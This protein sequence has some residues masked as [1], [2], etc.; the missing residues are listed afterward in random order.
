MDLLQ[1]CNVC[2]A[3]TLVT[4]FNIETNSLPLIEGFKTRAGNC[5][6]V[7]KDI[8]T[9]ITFNKPKPLLLVKPFYLSF[10]QC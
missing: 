3:G 1:W 6:I 8:P 9:L 4:L 10:C 2:C 7:H 5:A